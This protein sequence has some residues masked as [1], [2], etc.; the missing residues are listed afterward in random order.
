MK[1]LP[2][3]LAHA[4]RVDVQC[5]KAARR[6]G[7]KAFKL[8]KESREDKSAE[9][10]R[11]KE[12]LA[13]QLNEHAGQLRYNPTKLKDIYEHDVNKSEAQMFS[14]IALIRFRSRKG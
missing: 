14:E 3:V 11:I 8:A 12:I 6:M 5:K 7:E 10:R 1:K 2:A 13:N 4:M 9:K